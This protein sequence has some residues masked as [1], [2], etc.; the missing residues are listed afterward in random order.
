[1]LRITEP[2]FTAFRSNEHVEL[3]PFNGDAGDIE[4]FLLKNETAHWLHQ[5]VMLSGYLFKTHDIPLLGIFVAFDIAE[6]F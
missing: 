3:L 2:R 1:M 5:F 6:T 4:Y